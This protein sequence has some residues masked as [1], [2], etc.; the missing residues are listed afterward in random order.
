MR[1]FFA[2]AS[3]ALLCVGVLIVGWG[4]SAAAG[5]SQAPGVAPILFYSPTHLDFRPGSEV[6]TVDIWN[7][8]DGILQWSAGVDQPW[9]MMTPVAGIGYGRVTVTVDVMA[10]QRGRRHEAIITIDSN[11]GTGEITVFAFPPPPD[12][13]GTIGLYT[14][15]HGVNCDITDMAPG[16]LQIFV[17]HTDLATASAAEF[18]APVPACMIGT[19]WLADTEVFPV[20]LGDSQSGVSIGYGACYASPV[21][22]LTINLL[23]SGTSEQCCIYF[24]VPNPNNQDGRIQTVDC[25]LNLLNAEGRAAVINPDG[26]CACGGPLP[27]EATTWGRVKAMYRGE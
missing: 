5:E 12:H 15:A 22:I 8:G 23:T 24:I 25:L 7:G 14:N 18:A 2:T 20:S 11:G 10:L 6:Q 9:V 21:H 1:S 4:G 26:R 27:A 19:T 3:L 17:V 16:L 13:G